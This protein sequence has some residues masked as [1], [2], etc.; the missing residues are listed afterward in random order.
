MAETE[1]TVYVVYQ[2]SFYAAAIEHCLTEIGERYTKITTARDRLLDLA[3]EL[4]VYDSKINWCTEPKVVPHCP[5]NI[6]THYYSSARF[7][8]TRRF[9]PRNDRRINKRK[10]YLKQLTRRNDT[11]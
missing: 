7:H 9:N 4:S 3:D 8:L 2:G 6:S 10:S 11:N 1:P 5:V